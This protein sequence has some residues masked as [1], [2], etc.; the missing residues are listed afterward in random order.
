MS[1][2]AAESEWKGLGAAL[3]RFVFLPIYHF[4]MKLRRRFYEKGIFKSNRLHG[5][6][7]VSIGNIECGGTGKTPMV[8]HFVQELCARGCKPAVL[9]R[10]Y[11]SGMPSSEFSVLLNG[12]VVLG[13][14]Q[15]SGADEPVLMSHLLHDIPVVVGVDRYAAAL[16]YLGKYP[17]PTHWLLDDGF[18]HLQ[19]ERDFD[20]VLLGKAKWL[21]RESL[22]VAEQADML[23]SEFETTIKSTVRFERG[24][25]LPSRMND[26]GTFDAYRS[27]CYVLTAIAQPH[28]FINQLNHMGIP[29]EGRKIKADHEHFFKKDI[30][31]GKV[32]MMTQKDFFRDRD[33]FLNLSQPVFVLPMQITIP[34][35]SIAAFD[36]VF[37]H[38]VAYRP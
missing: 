29:V 28:R 38:L 1:G 8:I 17:K 27:G 10:G 30:P 13:H 36:K 34:D 26:Q 11:K 25:D 37:E 33:L 4:G 5:S 16:A 31:K 6:C 14:H 7:V 19:L 9:T 12:E 22:N 23:L 35:A 15:G 20:I 21:L 2:L 18:Q 3:L 24:F 32:L